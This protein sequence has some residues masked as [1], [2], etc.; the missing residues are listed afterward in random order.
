[1]KSQAMCAQE[2]RDLRDRE[3]LLVR[4]EQQIAALA[5]REE[6]GVFRH[7]VERRALVE[8]QDIPP[9][10]TDIVGALTIAALG[11]EGAD[12]AHV[13]ARQRAVEADMHEAAR[14]QERE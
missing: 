13:R 5:G 11:D 10:A 8:A 1:E 4:M 3:L 2:R 12:G 14:A 6:V 7:V 9:T